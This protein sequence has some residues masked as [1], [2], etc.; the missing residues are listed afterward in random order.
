MVSMMRQ[1]VTWVLVVG[2]LVGLAVVIVGLVL[3]IRGTPS[4]RR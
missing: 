3:V 1:P 2:F 4:R